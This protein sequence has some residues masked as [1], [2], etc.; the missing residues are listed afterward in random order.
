MCTSIWTK[1]EA[2]D[3]ESSSRL[4]GSLHLWQCKPPCAWELRSASV[5]VVPKL[6]LGEL[7]G[8]VAGPAW[9]LKVGWALGSGPWRRA[10][11]EISRWAGL[12]GRAY[13]SGCTTVSTTVSQILRGLSHR[14]TSYLGAIILEAYCGSSENTSK[15]KMII[16]AWTPKQ[17]GGTLRGYDPGFARVRV[18][19]WIYDIWPGLRPNTFKDKG[20]PREPRCAW[21]ARRP[22][23]WKQTIPNIS[24]GY[25][26]FGKK[27]QV[28]S[29]KQKLSKS[30]G[31][32]RTATGGNGRGAEKRATITNS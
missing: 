22:L 8:S 23:I 30:N 17:R 31:R 11:L 19:P 5:A 27:K 10:H 20:V 13:R 1:K 26:K 21:L 2:I 28:R 9:D 24:Y 25:E 29:A 15:T 7:R 14:R 12:W 32:Q 3:A 6:G 4:A 18:I 16:P